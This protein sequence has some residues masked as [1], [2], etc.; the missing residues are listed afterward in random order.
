MK[1]DSSITKIVRFITA[2]TFLV[3]KYLFFLLGYRF[4]AKTICHTI[5]FCNFEL[6][7]YRDNHFYI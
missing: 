1:D 3:F 6:Y 4:F 7:E 2:F 5:F